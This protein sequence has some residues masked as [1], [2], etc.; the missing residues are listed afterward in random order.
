MPLLMF[1]ILIETGGGDTAHA[2]VAQ[3]SHHQGLRHVQWSQ[4]NSDQE[5]GQ[6]CTNI[7]RESHRDCVLPRQVLFPL[8][9]SPLIKLIL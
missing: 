8:D 4:V 6:R 9:K 3:T 7:T 2:P 1:G 5:R